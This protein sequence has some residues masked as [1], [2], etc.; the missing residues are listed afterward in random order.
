MSY[1]HIYTYL[2]FYL[3]Q[4]PLDLLKEGT[5]VE[6]EIFTDNLN[7]EVL[8]RTAS[9]LRWEGPL[10]HFGEF[11]DCKLHAVINRKLLSSLNF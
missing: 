7:L 2:Q 3:F 5:C 10:Y 6:K 4:L 1:W 11:V 8:I 9:N